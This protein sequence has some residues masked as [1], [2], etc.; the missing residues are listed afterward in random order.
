[1]AFNSFLQ[2][3]SGIYVLRKSNHCDARNVPTDVFLVKTQTLHNRGKIFSLH[4]FYR[5]SHDD[6]ESN[7]LVLVFVQLILPYHRSRRR[8]GR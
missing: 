7:I 6:K 2:S 5:N 8:L 4:L 1:M 3:D